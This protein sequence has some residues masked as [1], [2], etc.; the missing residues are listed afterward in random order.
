M[1]SS[2]LMTNY[3]NRLPAAVAAIPVGVPS[4]DANA[5]FGSGRTMMRVEGKRGLMTDDTIQMLGNPMR[6]G[7]SGGAWYANGNFVG[8][9]SRHNHHDTTTEWSPYYDENVL[10]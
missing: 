1:I 4:G 10:G 3:Y 5:D 7:N 6:K 8:N 2:L 9:N